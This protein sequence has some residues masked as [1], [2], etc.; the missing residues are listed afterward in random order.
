MTA[1][2]RNLTV[3]LV[4]KVK[5][6]SENGEA[7]VKKM[8]N[9]REKIRK[10]EDLCWNNNIWIIVSKRANRGNRGDKKKNVRKC[11]VFE[12]YEFLD[13]K[14]QWMREQWV[15]TDPL[16]GTHLRSFRTLGLKEEF[17]ERK[18]VRLHTKYKAIRTTLTSQ[19]R[20]QKLRLIKFDAKWFA[21]WNAMSIHMINYVYG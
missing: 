2:N 20:S 18:N 9:R 7:E 10:L 3:G 16:R 8:G 17:P 4:D 12:R 19:Q 1:A 5:K 6:F 14:S 15:I 13:G 11:S 21:S